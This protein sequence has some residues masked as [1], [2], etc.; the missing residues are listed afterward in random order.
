MGYSSRWW[1][2][3]AKQVRGLGMRCGP[4]DHMALLLLM[5]TV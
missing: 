3:T 4:R 2:Y 1:P 5:Q